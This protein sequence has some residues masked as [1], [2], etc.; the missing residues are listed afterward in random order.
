MNNGIKWPPQAQGQLPQA[1]RQPH[2]PAQPPTSRPIPGVLQP[3]ASAIQTKTPPTAPPVYRPQPL[4]RVLQMKAAVHRQPN[5]CQSNA[6]RPPRRPAAPTIRQPNPQT[7]QP[8]T[9]Q[10]NVVQSKIVQSKIVQ[11]KTAAGTQARRPP[12]SPHL[13]AP[14]LTV[15]RLNQS[16]SAASQLKPT[17][18]QAKPS[19]TAPARPKAAPDI[20]NNRANAAIQPYL[21]PSMRP[22]HLQVSAATGPATT[23]RPAFW[24]ETETFMYAGHGSMRSTLTQLAQY[25]QNGGMEYTQ[26][27]ECGL[28]YPQQALNIDHITPWSALGPF[29]TRKA[30]IEAYNNVQNLQILCASC[31]L[32][33]TSNPAWHYTNEHRQG[34]RGPAAPTAFQLAITTLALSGKYTFGATHKF[35]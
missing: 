19:S 28:Y 18:S 31:N 16:A 29:T 13:S 2:R 23:A 7:A 8:K 6:C 1:H 17:A 25:D 14:G 35:L 10:P 20:S 11:P 26:C 32:Q 30:Q 4:P 34:L 22:A 24:Q 15:R 9:A 5:A 12:S 27:A 3:K 21:P 33:K